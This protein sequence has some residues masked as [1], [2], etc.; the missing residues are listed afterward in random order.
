MVMTSDGNA[1][2][3]ESHPMPPQL[4]QTRQ[5]DPAVIMAAHACLC[6][7]V[8]VLHYILFFFVFFFFPAL[9]I[10]QEKKRRKKQN[11]FCALGSS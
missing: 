2:W 1:L 7:Q 9:T 6:Q 8:R 4:P 5:T 10:I 3:L 11:Y